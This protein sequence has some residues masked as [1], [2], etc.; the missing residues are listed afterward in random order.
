MRLMTMLAIAASLSTPLMAENRVDGMRPDAPV[1]A[2]LGG[3]LLLAEVP[4]ARLLVTGAVVL[5]GVAFSLT[6][7]ARGKERRG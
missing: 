3:A 1:L 6:H 5:G 7:P 4:S 2:A